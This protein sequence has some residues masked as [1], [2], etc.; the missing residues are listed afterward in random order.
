M[1]E[2]SV[3]STQRYSRTRASWG[4][5]MPTWRAWRCEEGTVAAAG[6]Q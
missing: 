6:G 2:V 3:T 5:R 4:V 1:S